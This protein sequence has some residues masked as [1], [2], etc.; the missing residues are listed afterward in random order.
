MT[1]E[2]EACNNMFMEDMNLKC[3]NELVVSHELA[4]GDETFKS[5][6]IHVLSDYRKIRLTCTVVE[7]LLSELK[8]LPLSASDDI[9]LDWYILE[10]DKCN[11]KV[12]SLFQNVVGETDS[13][14]IDFDQETFED[15]KLVSNFILSDDALSDQPLNNMRKH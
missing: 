3:F 11:N 6:P 5:L 12:Y 2:P 8:P 9:Y 1:H 15:G 10:Q 14:N 13:L 4:L 7:E